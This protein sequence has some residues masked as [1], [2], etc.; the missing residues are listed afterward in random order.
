MERD[1]KS[2]WDTPEEGVKKGEIEGEKS[3]AGWEEKSKK[4]DNRPRPPPIPPISPATTVTGTATL[5]W[6]CWASLNAVPRELTMAPLLSL[7]RHL[8][9]ET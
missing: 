3:E 4:T 9:I 5:E 7:E 8:H 6:D 1:V 2:T